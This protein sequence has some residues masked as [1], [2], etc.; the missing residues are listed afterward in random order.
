MDGLRIDRSLVIPEAELKERF[1]PAGGPGGQHANKAST[2]VELVWN[3]ARSS[4][5]TP[6]QRERLL[7]KLANRVDSEGNLRIVSDSERSQLRNRAEAERRL[8][9]LV[10]GALRRERTRR[11]TRPT[12]GSQEKRL[13]EKKRRSEIK[14]ARRDPQL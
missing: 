13:E 9:H 4:A 12:K 1:T 8:V 6:L 5:V 11:P 10:A 14:R 2:R 7:E 3:V